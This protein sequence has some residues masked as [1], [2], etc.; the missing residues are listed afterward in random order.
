MLVVIVKGRNSNMVASFI[1]GSDTHELLV[2]HL[3]DSS[4]LCCEAVI[5][6]PIL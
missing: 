4:W 6:I 3:I 2:H 1:M 5:V